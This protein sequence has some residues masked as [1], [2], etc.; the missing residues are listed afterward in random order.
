[1][2]HRVFDSTFER[3]VLRSSEPVLVNCIAEECGPCRSISPILEEFAA[4]MVGR[5]KV[6]KIDIHQNPAV[7]ALYDIHGLPTLIVFTNGEIA[8]RRVGALMREDELR[9]WVGEAVGVAD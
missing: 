3:E 9:G 4:N 1:M 5:V 7:R 8:G 6:E 2:I